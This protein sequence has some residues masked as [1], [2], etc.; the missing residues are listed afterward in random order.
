VEEL[1]EP[2]SSRG[3]EDD[4]RDRVA[5]DAAVGPSIAPPNARDRGLHLRVRRSSSWTI[6]SL[7]IDCRAVAREGLERLRLAGP[8][9][10]VTA[11]ATG[12]SA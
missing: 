6:S 4:V 9:A 2:L 1:L 3:R 10:P 8:D 11:T 7:E 12:S 5:V